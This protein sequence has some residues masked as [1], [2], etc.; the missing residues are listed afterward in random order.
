[1]E[2]PIQPF[3]VYQKGNLYG[4]MN[5]RKEFIVPCTYPDL[6]I[7]KIEDGILHCEAVFD[8]TEVDGIYTFIFNEQGIMLIPD[9]K[10]EFNL[11]PN[12]LIAIEND[13]HA[14]GFVNRQ[15]EIVIPCQYYNFEW[16]QTEH[17]LVQA[18]NH[19]WGCI[20]TSGKKIIPC[21]YKSIQRTEQGFYVVERAGKWRFMNPQNPKSAWLYEKIE[22]LKPC[23]KA[24]YN[25]KWIL[26]DGTGQA[27]NG[28]EYDDIRVQQEP[29]LLVSQGGLTGVI[30]A[31]TA[32]IV[33]PITYPSASI[34]AFHSEQLTLRQDGKLGVVDKWN[35]TILPYSYDE[36]KR[37]E[38]IIIA[39]KEDLWGF[40]DVTGQC[41]IPCQFE[42]YVFFQNHFI[43]VQQSNKWG[44]VNFK[45]IYIAKC[46]FDEIKV[47]DAHYAQVRQGAHWGVISIAEPQLPIC[48]YDE[49]FTFKEG[50]AKVRIGSKY[51]FI[52]AQGALTV[53]VK[54]TDASNFN[55]GMAKVARG[56]HI[57]YY[58]YVNLLGEETIPLIYE[59]AHDFSDG[60]AQVRYN[61]CGFVDKE[62]NVVIPFIYD[63]GSW[64]NFRYG[65]A[66]V[67][68]EGQ[69]GAIDK[70]NRIVIPFKYESLGGFNENGFTRA[71]YDDD[72]YFSIDRTGYVYYEPD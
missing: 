28:V 33:F 26:L 36:I 63:G 51:G 52:N 67:T 11:L 50:M 12:G 55:E 7:D 4:I 61:Q 21:F 9:V 47:L 54:Y 15:G 45:G 42:T 57:Q 60:L 5:A 2:Y 29:Y 65:L 44:L 56:K 27:V 71:E 59:S 62:G 23:W 14:W 48:Q 16:T 70:E 38:Q 69:M 24:L 64:S 58:G 19:R 53:P 6:W 20:D 22:Y 37:F 66:T 25:E 40:W 8:K 17:M 49:I 13:K 46:Q 43:S 18:R 30:H 35:Q 41:L 68:Y 10:T 32:E 34:H 72:K 39:Q 1:M 31:S 3:M